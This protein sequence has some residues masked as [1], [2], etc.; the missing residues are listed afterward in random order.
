MCWEIELEKASGRSRSHRS[1]ILKPRAELFNIPP[2]KIESEELDWH[3]F[4]HADEKKISYQQTVFSGNFVPNS[5]PVHCRVSPFHLFRSHWGSSSNHPK[6]N[7]ISKRLNNFS[8]AIWFFNRK[9]PHKTS[10][11][12]SKY[13]GQMSRRNGARGHRDLRH[14]A[15]PTTSWFL[16]FLGCYFF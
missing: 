11:H 6:M 15:G 8:S 13:K 16:T 4:N 10:G 14:G 3:W 9:T 12:S 5:T 1:L 7:V 2:T